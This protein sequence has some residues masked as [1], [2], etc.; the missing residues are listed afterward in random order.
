MIEI[1]LSAFEKTHD[2][3]VGLVR[4][5]FES[6]PVQSKKHVGCE[7]RDTYVAVPVAVLAVSPNSEPG[8]AFRGPCRA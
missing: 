7:E 8:R 4:I 2:E 1:T 6:P 5:D 3:A